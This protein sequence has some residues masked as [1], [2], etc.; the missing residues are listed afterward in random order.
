MTRLDAQTARRLILLV[1]GVYILFTGGIE[2]SKLSGVTDSLTA[3]ELIRKVTTLASLTVGAV[4]G[5]YLAS[6]QRQN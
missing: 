3:A 2:L 6:G 5:F 4:I 1:A